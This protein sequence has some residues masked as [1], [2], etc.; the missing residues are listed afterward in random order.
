VGMRD[1]R[2]DRR[3]KAAGDVFPAWHLLPGQM[4]LKSCPCA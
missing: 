2:E 1:K 4:Y 3:E